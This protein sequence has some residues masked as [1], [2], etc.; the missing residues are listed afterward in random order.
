[1]SYITFNYYSRWAMISYRLA[2]ISAAVTYGVVVYKQ[3][4]ARG[5]LSGSPLQIAVKL[6]GD[7]NVQYLGMALRIQFHLN[8]Q[9]DAS[10]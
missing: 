9:H 10:Y 3:Y 7:E 6:L 5:K 2:F 4:F 8:N 1:M